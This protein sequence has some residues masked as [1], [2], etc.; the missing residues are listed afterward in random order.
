LALT[1]AK[2]AIRT[3]VFRPSDRLSEQGFVCLTINLT[4]Q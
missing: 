2:K 1:Y 3:G 4:E